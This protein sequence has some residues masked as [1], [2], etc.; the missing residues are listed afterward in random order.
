MGDQR[1]AVVQ[2]NVLVIVQ[3]SIM[4]RNRAARSV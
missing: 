4:F 3:P 2:L 1:A